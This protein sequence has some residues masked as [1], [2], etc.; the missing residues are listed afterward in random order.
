LRTCWLYPWVLKLSLGWWAPSLQWNLNGG[1]L[2]RK[3]RLPAHR[4][5]FRLSFLW[6]SNVGCWNA[7]ICCTYECKPS[8]P[9][10]ML[11]AC[12]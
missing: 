4:R 10:L 9:R 3:R 2:W 12:K 5:H 6:R 1:A 11:V 8:T 7:R